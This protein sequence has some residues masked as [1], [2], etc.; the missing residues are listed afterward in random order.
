MD[1]ERERE[2]EK[3]M[4][5]GNDIEE[6]FHKVQSILILTFVTRVGPWIDRRISFPRQVRTLLGS[7]VKGPP[8]L[9]IFDGLASTRRSTVWNPG[10]VKEGYCY[11]REE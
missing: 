4:K 1:G 9:P 10:G 2:K 8:G 5:V 3:G 6:E 7:R 11:G